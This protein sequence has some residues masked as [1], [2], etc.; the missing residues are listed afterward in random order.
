MDER[1]FVY[2]DDTDVLLRCWRQ[3][4]R[5]WYI[6]EA[7]LWHK[8]SSLTSSA[9]DFTDIQFA[10][11]RA[12]FRQKNLTPTLARTS[13]VGLTRRSTPFPSF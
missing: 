9:S 2:Y 11:N 7:R 12:Y 8:V 10:K 5:L 6:P 13:G 1:Y 3:D 4:L